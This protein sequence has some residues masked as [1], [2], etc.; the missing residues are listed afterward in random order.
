MT[1]ADPVVRVVLACPDDRRPALLAALRDTPGLRVVH[2]TASPG[3]VPAA[4]SEAAPALL[5]VDDDVDGGAVAVVRAVMHAAP[6][7]VL[8]LQAAGGDGAALLDAGAVEVRDREA[9][10]GLAERCRVLARVAVVRRRARTPAVRDGGVPAEHG[11][12]AVAASTGGPPALA[13]LLAGLGGLTLPVLVVQH[14][15]ADFLPSL[16]TWLADTG[17]LPVS[18]AAQDDVVRPGH[19]HLAPGDQHLRLLPGGRLA[20]AT[21]PAGLHVPSADVL[22][23]SVAACDDVRGIGVL[24]TG[25][26]RDGAAGLLALRTAGGRTIAQDE[27]TSTVWGMPKVAVELGA[28]EQVLPLE[29]IATAVR[30]L[31]AGAR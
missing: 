5:L 12:L 21:T 10:D 28:A 29:Q 18:V 13:R 17:P 6:A 9:L 2:A 27:A 14:I 3:R 16:A 25:M 1:P 31:V 19:V 30:A 26:G 22:F 4:L 8:V 11:V 20:L 7:P 23:S 15:A 24:L